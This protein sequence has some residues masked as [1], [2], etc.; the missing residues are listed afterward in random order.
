MPFVETVMAIGGLCLIGY[1]L[2]LFVT[3]Q[4]DMTPKYRIVTYDRFGHPW[5]GASF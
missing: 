4:V 2:Y 5:P 3:G 1:C